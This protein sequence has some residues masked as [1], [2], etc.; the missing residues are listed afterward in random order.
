MV[1]SG[2]GKEESGG[3]VGCFYWSLSGRGWLG[4][5]GGCAE[6]VGR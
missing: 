1:Q 6:G 2:G 4:F 3:F 5:V